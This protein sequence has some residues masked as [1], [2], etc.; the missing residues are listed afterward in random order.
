LLT[1]ILLVVAVIQ[2]I[3]FKQD[4]ASNSHNHQTTQDSK[5]VQTNTKTV[6]KVNPIPPVKN[7]THK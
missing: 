2:I 5:Q 3:I 6:G 7:E 1:A 4:T